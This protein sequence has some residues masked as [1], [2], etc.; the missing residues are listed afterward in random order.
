MAQK[1]EWGK[2]GPPKTFNKPAS[3]G[4]NPPRRPLQFIQLGSRAVGKTYNFRVLGNYVQYYKYVVQGQDGKWRSAITEDPDNC[5]IVAKHGIRPKETYAVNVLDR[6]DGQI[7]ILEGPRSI[8]EVFANYHKMTE[9]NP[10]GPNGADFSVQVT[11][12]KGKDYYR[13]DMVKRT[14][15]AAKEAEL[16]KNEGLY[17]LERIFKATPPDKIESVLY[18]NSVPAVAA[19]PVVSKQEDDRG[20]A[21]DLLEEESESETEASSEGDSLEEGGD[22]IGF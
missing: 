1:M 3:N 4:N 6:A 20:S 16:L 19:K 5:P 8:F 15:F 11:G 7:K 14:P 18:G 22:D 13:T 10:G 9:K 12:Q 17:K 21:S 2:F